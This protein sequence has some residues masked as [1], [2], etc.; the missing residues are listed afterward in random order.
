MINRE[1][2]W[3]MNRKRKESRVG[4][5]FF[6]PPEMAK[7]CSINASMP[8]FPFFNRQKLAVLSSFAFRTVFGKCLSQLLRLRFLQ[9]NIEIDSVSLN[10]ALIDTHKHNKI[11][12]VRGSFSLTSVEIMS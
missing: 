7:I 9:E 4:V 8:T 3:Q 1:N 2:N 10:C 5:L 11:L 6:N 12:S